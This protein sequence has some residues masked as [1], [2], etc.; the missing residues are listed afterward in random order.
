MLAGGVLYC[1]WMIA[2]V[3]NFTRVDATAACAGET[4]G[5]AFATIADMG[6][7]SVVN[8]RLADEPGVGAEAGLVAAAGLRYYHLPCDP[9]APASEIAERFLAIVADVS[10]QPLY[11]HCRSANRVGGLWAIKRVV[12]DGWTRPDAVAE[13]Q[14]IGLKS[15][16]MLDF[17]QRFLDARG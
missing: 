4:P 15:P 11:I 9:K 16:E 8:V 12:Q 2:G 10:N 7:T 1:G 3:V 14:R 6:F 17:V 13:G 5:D